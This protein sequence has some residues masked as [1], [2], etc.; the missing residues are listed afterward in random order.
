MIYLNLITKLLEIVGLREGTLDFDRPHGSSLM[1][2]E[3]E[4]LF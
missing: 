4:C 3:P 2:Y 1:I